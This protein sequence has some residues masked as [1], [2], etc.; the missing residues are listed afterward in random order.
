MCEMRIIK[1]TSW[2]LVRITQNN[3]CAQKLGA[4]FQ[5]TVFPGEAEPL[6]TGR[7]GRVIPGQV[8]LRESWG[9]LLSAGMTQLRDK[10]SFIFK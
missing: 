10:F 8:P 5:P 3:V 1:P 4:P 2:D 6:L 7:L 9:P